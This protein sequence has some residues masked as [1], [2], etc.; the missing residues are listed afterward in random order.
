LR[1]SDIQVI[2]DSLSTLPG[3]WY[4]D[5]VIDLRRP[6]K[7]QVWLRSSAIDGCN[8]PAISFERIGNL[9][10]IS[11]VAPEAS[12]GGMVIGRPFATIAA[13]FVYLSARIEAHADVGDGGSPPWQ[14]GVVEVAALVP[15]DLCA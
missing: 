10:W 13:A 4:L 8:R 11:I 9:V 5:S 7:P 15:P 6:G 3:E 1:G 14:D 2:A 12:E